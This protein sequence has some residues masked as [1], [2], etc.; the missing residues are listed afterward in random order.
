MAIKSVSGKGYSGEIWV[1]VGFNL[2]K[3]INDIFVI[4]HLET[5]GLGSKM[6]DMAYRGQYIGKDPGIV[7]LRVSKDGGVI[8]AISG[9]TIT[10]RAFT[11][12][13]QLAYDTYLQYLEDGKND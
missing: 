3:T 2:D 7:D 5:P 12:A 6:T 10:S 4:E 11:E 9:A 1:M 13:V 8:Q